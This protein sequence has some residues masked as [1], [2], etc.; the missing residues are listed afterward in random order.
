[1]LIPEHTPQA[2]MPEG[3]L[4]LRN[5]LHDHLTNRISTLTAMSVYLNSTGYLT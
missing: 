2:F 5:A 4:I 3:V 1:M